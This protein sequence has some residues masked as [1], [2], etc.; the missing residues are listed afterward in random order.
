MNVYATAD[1]LKEFMQGGL[2]VSIEE[3]EEPLLKRFCIEASRMFDSWATNGVPP[4]RRFYPYIATKDYDYLSNYITRLN[5]F[6]DLLEA[7]TLTTENGA[8]SISASDYVLATSK[9]DYNRTPFSQ[10]LLVENATVTQFSY[11]GTVRKA[12]AL[13]G[14]WGYHDEWSDAWEDSGDSVQDD[15]LSDSATSIEVNDADGDDINGLPFRFKV[16]QLLRIEDEY[17]WIT[18]IDQT[19]DPNTLTVRRG[20][21]GSTAASHAKNKA[22]EI[23][24][25]MDDLKFAIEA[26]AKYLYK[27]RATIGSAEDRPLATA[28]GILVLPNRLP[29]EV[30]RN[31]LTYRKEGL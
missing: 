1:D 30:T 5:L 13:T 25:P 12:N 20:R 6:D 15:P 28:D 10:V 7:T 26:L 14:I 9:G 19:S 31:L 24:R 22:I 3:E 27:R 2:K 17:L 18:G 16:Q 23:Y 8:T 11:S 21:N 29:D 4:K